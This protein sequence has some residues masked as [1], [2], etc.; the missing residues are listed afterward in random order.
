MALGKSLVNE[1]VTRFRLASSIVD[2]LNRPFTRE[3]EKKR[4]YIFRL[5]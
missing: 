1:V 5:M 3:V 4:Q 2:F